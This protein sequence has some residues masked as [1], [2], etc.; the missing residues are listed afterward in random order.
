ME[1]LKTKI[2]S[3]C[4]LNL[5]LDSFGNLANGIS[6]KMYECKQCVKNRNSRY[7]FENKEKRKQKQV[8]NRELYGEEIRAQE[9]RNYY[10]HRRQ[11]IDYQ[12]EYAQRPE[13]KGR[14]AANKTKLEKEKYWSDNQ[15]RLAFILRRRMGAAIRGKQKES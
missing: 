7:R 15:F 9:S 14:I 2:C 10:K 6:G 4:K 5:P 11:R 13:N 1:S 12:K 3:T 8:K